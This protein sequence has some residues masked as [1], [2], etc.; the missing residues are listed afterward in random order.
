MKSQVVALIE[1]HGVYGLGGMDGCACTDFQVHN[2]SVSV[3]CHRPSGGPSVTVRGKHFDVT[4]Q[5]VRD[6][7][8]AVLRS[9]RTHWRYTDVKIHLSD[10]HGEGE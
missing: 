8:A 9:L 10:S 7:A 6:V 2:V 5:E 3:Q 4:P 1:Q